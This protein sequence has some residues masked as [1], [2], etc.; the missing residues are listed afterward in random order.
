MAGTDTAAR[1]GTYAERLLDNAY[2][3]ENLAD[4]I[5][6]LRQAYARAS[7][8]R[9]EPTRDEKF[10][11]QVLQA[12]G[13]IREAASALKEGRTKPKRRV[14]R[15][16]IVVLGVGAIGAGAALAASED[17]RN[18]VFGSDRSATGGGGASPE[19][20]SETPEAPA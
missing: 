11:R 4:A 17:L 5:G 13:S 15:R 8:R 18:K 3:Q 14:G 9:V 19:G 12:A 7:K 10:R 16:L 1:A 2:V 20:P 6:N